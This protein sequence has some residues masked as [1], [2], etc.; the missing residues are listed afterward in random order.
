[1]LT[2]QVYGII[3]FFSTTHSFIF[4]AMAELVDNA[5]DAK[6]TKLEI[7]TGRWQCTMIGDIELW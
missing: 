4:G 1:M 5:R 6:S 7:Y 2:L 3:F